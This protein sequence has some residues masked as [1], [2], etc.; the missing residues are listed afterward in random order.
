[1]GWV[2]ANVIEALRG[3]HQ[4]AI[5]IRCDLDPPLRLWLGVNDIPAG[6]DS[7]DPDTDQVYL[8]GGRLRDI[9]NL[10]ISINGVA[11]RV[12]FQIAGIDP[13]TAARIDPDDYDVRGADFHVGIT[14][15]DEDYQPMSSIIPLVCGK[16]S[17]TSEKSDPV[18]GSEPA[19]VT[20]GL[21]VGF[22]PVTRSRNAAVLWSDAQH[23]ALYPGDLF[24]KHTARQAR[25]TSVTWPRF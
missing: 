2:P 14:T 19:T 8:G 3:S 13:E 23:Q 4:L 5:F 24:C 7:V 17:Y 11:D 22:G 10:E 15:L 20:M 25:G 12:E 9:P 6:I 16:A 18:S 1:M 21:S